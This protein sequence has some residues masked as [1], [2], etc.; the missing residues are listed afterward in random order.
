MH[1]V[2]ESLCALNFAVDFKERRTRSL[3]IK[4]NLDLV[5]DNDLNRPRF[6]CI[7]ADMFATL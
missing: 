7:L 4:V 1:G 6:K 5:V 3:M 2:S